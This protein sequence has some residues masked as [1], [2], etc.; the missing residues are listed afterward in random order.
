MTYAKLTSNVGAPEEGGNS[1][2]TK[3]GDTKKLA[4]LS[5]ANQ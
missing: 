2:A 1:N 5:G 3:E 4:T